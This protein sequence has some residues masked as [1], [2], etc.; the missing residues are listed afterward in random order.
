MPYLK[1][2]DNQF[3]SVAVVTQHKKYCFTDKH[4]SGVQVEGAMELV[5]WDECCSLSG[6]AAWGVVNSTER[7]VD[8]AMCGGSDTLGARRNPS[9]IHTRYLVTHYEVHTI[10]GQI[11][12][13]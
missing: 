4:C 12:S 7:G 13:V 10:Q 3:F 5:T 1:F 8:C 11:V 6:A 2:V 9:G